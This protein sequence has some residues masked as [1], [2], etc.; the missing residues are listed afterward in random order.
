MTLSFDDA[1]KPWV[2]RRWPVRKD[3]Y[4]KQQLLPPIDGTKRHAPTHIIYHFA[5]RIASE[6]RSVKNNAQGLR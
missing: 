5:A 4:T 2:N 6:E 1:R 3:G